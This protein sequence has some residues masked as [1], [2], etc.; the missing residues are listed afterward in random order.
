VD[1]LVV[2]NARPGR[3]HD[4]HTPRGGGSKER[5][6]D[7]G[8]RAVVAR[9]PVLAGAQVDHVQGAPAPASNTRLST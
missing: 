6:A 5:L 7:D 2:G 8:R 1:E 9:E 4:R 3:V